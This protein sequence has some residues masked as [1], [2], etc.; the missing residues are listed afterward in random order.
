MP[1]G[2]QPVL[3]GLGGRVDAGQEFSL[4][5]TGLPSRSRAGRY[6]TI[7]VALLVLGWGVFAASSARAPSGGEAR[8]AQLHER[9]DKLMADLVRLEQQF[10]SGT[11]DAARHDARRAD[12]VAQLERVYGELDE[13]GGPGAGQGLPA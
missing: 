4:A 12:L 8:Q 1:A 5:L 9:R 7:V 10:R 2:G 6:A 11:L 13:Y 3:L